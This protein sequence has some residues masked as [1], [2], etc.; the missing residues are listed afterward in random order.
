MVLCGL[1][2]LLS[3]VVLLDVCFWFICCW[4]LALL[5]LIG[6]FNSVACLVLGWFWFMLFV[7]CYLA[8]VLFVWDLCLLVVCL[9]LWF[10]GLL[11]FLRVMLVML[12]KFLTF[13]FNLIVLYIFFYLAVVV[14]VSVLCVGLGI[15]GV[16]GLLVTFG[17]FCVW[18]FVCFVLFVC[19]WFCVLVVIVDCWFSCL[20]GLVVFGLLFWELFLMFICVVA[21][22]CC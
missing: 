3:L 4:I 10:A 7:I 1:V 5:V 11:C 19:A 6:Y 14:C 15:R 18:L 2:Y 17:V 9:Y 16:F 8:W 13:G 22:L 20:F 12:F 21:W